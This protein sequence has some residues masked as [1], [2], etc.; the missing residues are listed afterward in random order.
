MSVFRISRRQALVVGGTS[1]ALLGALK[2]KGAESDREHLP[3]KLDGINV[4]S[5]EKSPEVSAANKYDDLQ[6]LVVDPRPD[7]SVPN[8]FGAGTK[9]EA[10]PA[11]VSWMEKVY[12]RFSMSCVC[13]I[14]YANNCAHYLTNAF[15]LE[16]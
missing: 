2:G 1:V 5:V 16:G 14:S 11:T 4:I 15:A 8:G 6:T 10:R 13:G 12:N 7:W 3:Q 9:D